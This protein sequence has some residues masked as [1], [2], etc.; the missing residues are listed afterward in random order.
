MS[1]VA[2]NQEPEDRMQVLRALMEAHGHDVLR[3]LYS[4][5]KD[6]HI[7]ED[8]SQEVFIKVYDHLDTF[9]KESSYKT[10]VLRIAMNRAK[11]Y[12]RSQ[13]SKLMPVEDLTYLPD[14]K[15][16]EQIVVT[17]EED[18]YLW[19]SV[20]SLP[21]I[22]RETLFLFYEQEL[23]IDEIATITQMTTATVKTRLHRGRAMLRDALKGS[24]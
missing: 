12:L 7:A 3:V 15:T 8:L 23:S 11:D 20:L 19:R 4:Y 5:V 16:P 14:S 17:K 24:E 2:F 10:W 18:A 9:R 22:Y 13:A 6:K 21:E 1:F